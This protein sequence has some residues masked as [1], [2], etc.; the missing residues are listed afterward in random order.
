T[1]R[2]VVGVELQLDLGPLVAVV[3][4]VVDLELVGEEPRIV[5]ILRLRAGPA[6]GGDLRL[7]SEGEVRLHERDE[8]E[9]RDAVAVLVLEAS[10]LVER[11][12]HPEQIEREL[13]GAGA[14]DGERLKPGADHAALDALVVRMAVGRRD[15]HLAR[16]AQRPR[17]IEL[18]LHPRGSVLEGRA[19]GGIRNGNDV[20]PANFGIVASAHRGNENG[21][22]DSHETLLSPHRSTSTS[23]A[24][25][26]ALRVSEWM[27]ATGSPTRTRVGVVPAPSPERGSDG[28]LYPPV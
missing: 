1:A 25:R 16:D 18:E 23:R 4:L 13:T 9:A 21:N 2:D 22:Q 20:K 17:R 19:R 7:L 8:L 24:S 6:L 27:N 26:R 12:L 3:V 28:R 15:L 14:V 11:D 5:R 10:A